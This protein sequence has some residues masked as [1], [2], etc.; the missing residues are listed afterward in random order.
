MKTGFERIAEKARAD[1]SFQFTSLMHHV[2]E[3]RLRGNL[4]RIPARSSAGI[5]KRG[6]IASKAHFTDWTKETIPHLKDQLRR[7][8]WFLRGHYGYYG[9][10]GISGNSLSLLFKMYRFVFKH[11]QKVLSSRSQ[12]GRLS[13]EKYVKIIQHFPILRPSITHPN[14]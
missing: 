12:S 7:L 11:W 1:K 13:F 2:N 6:L 5:D 4:K 14:I 3:E 8:N 10:Y 9:Y